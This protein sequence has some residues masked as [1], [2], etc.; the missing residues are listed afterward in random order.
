MREAKFKCIKCVRGYLDF[1]RGR[2]YNGQIF[3][4]GDTFITDDH[5]NEIKFFDTKI[6]FIE[7]KLN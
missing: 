2:V 1:T 4:N 3:D 6:V 5:N 7:V